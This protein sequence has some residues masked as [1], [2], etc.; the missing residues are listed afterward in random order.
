MTTVY[1]KTASAASATNYDAVSAAPF[2]ETDETA[3]SELDFSKKRVV[4]AIYKGWKIELA[5]L[6]E[7]EMDYF[8]QLGTYQAPQISF[9]NIN[10]YDITIQQIRMQVTG[11]QITVLKN[12]PE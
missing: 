11:A 4:H 9:D 3:Y 12:E 6:T 8:E 7:A 10:Y 2:F 5:F 1:F